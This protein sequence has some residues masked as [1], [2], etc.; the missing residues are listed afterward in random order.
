MGETLVSKG[1][2]R[3]IAVVSL[4]IKKRHEHEKKSHMSYSRMA[5]GGQ[6]IFKHKAQVKVVTMTNTHQGGLG[7]VSESLKASGRLFSAYA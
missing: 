1:P 2:E 6:P 4:A 3:K 7:R 5:E